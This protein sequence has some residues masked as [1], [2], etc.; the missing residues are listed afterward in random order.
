MEKTI[1]DKDVFYKITWSESRPCNRHVIRGIPSM[2]GIVCL[3]TEKSS[4]QKYLLFY[5]CWKSGLRVGLRNLLDPDLTPFHELIKLSEKQELLFRYTMIDT[6]PLD[7]KDIMYWL[8]KE[9]LPKYN[10]SEDFND[11]ERYKDIYLKELI[12]E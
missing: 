4:V 7:V 12:E 5:G 3:F 6:H 8:I 11:S 10:N 9:Y 2:P 1:Q